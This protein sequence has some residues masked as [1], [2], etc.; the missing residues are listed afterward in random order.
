MI[1][2]LYCSFI[3]YNLLS[4]WAGMTWA[5]SWC[6]PSRSLLSCSGRGESLECKSEKTCWDTCGLTSEEKLSGHAQQKTRNSFTAS[7]Q[8]AGV[9]LF[10]GKQGSSCITATLEDKSHWMSFYFPPV[11]LL[12][13]MSYSV[14]YHSITWGELINR[15]E[16]VGFLHRQIVISDSRKCTRETS[17]Q[18]STQIR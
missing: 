3:H 9:W 4:Y 12:N 18:A 6:P 15:M 17:E 5:L 16:I 8:P 13:I 14:E 1:S 2:F 10:P 7:H 11:L